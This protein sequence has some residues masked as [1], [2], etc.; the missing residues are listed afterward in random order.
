MRNPL[1][2]S[3]LKQY[4]LEASVLS[5]MG[6]ILSLGQNS[7]WQLTDNDG[8]STLKGGQSSEQTDNT[9]AIGH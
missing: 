4:L 9:D 6:T 8:R 2:L 1:D 3:H 5:D 7:L